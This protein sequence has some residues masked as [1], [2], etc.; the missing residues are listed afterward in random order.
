MWTLFNELNLHS[1]NKNE[2]R[3]Y[4]SAT[5][6][7]NCILNKW[8]KLSRSSWSW[9]ELHWNSQA[10]W[11][12]NIWLKSN[13]PRGM[14]AGRFIIIWERKIE[15]TQQ[16]VHGPRV[17]P[18]TGQ[19]LTSSATGNLPKKKKLFFK[20]ILSKHFY[21]C[22]FVIVDVWTCLYHPMAE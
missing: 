11:C 13:Q 9:G 1:K 21:V 10:L 20:K 5:G 22:T 7:T 17:P 16:V 8:R 14:N 15:Q 12:W 6:M 2:E 3:K 18:T 19:L 4:R